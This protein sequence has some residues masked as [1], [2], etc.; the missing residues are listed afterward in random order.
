MTRSQNFVRSVEMTF[1]AT[2][3]E[4]IFCLEALPIFPILFSTTYSIDGDLLSSLC[5]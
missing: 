1:Q 2:R 3:Y 4:E 5:N